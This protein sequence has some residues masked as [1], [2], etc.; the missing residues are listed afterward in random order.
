[1]AIQDHNEVSGYNGLPLETEV[2]LSSGLRSASLVQPNDKISCGKD[3]APKVR[4][5]YTITKQRERWTDEEHNKFLEAL[6]LHGRAWRKI[7]EHVGTKSAVQIRSHAQKYFT[8]VLRETAGSSISSVESIEIPPPRPKRKPSHPYPRKLVEFPDKAISNAGQPMRSNSLKS[9]E[10]DQENQ[11]PK[12]VLSAFGLDTPGY[13]DS[14]KPNGSPSE[15]DGSAPNAHSSPDL[16]TLQKFEL[17]P[18]E[19]VSTKEDA[20]EE[21][22]G[23]TF[24]LFGT[25]LLVTD[26]TMK[27]SDITEAPAGFAP[28]GR[29]VEDKVEKEVDWCGS[30]ITSSISDG[31]NDENP[32]IEARSHMNPYRKGEKLSLFGYL[33]TPREPS[34]I[35]EILQRPIGFV[36]YKRFIAERENQPLPITVEEKE[37]QRLRLSLL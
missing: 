13:S 12:S 18:R 6:K 35:S 24:K 37:G 19:S 8:K 3:H 33:T 31:D 26:P 15:E 29:E 9:S 4:K 22:C 21:T 16:Q 5:P 20:A 17:F 32:D 28:W 1:M 2:F 23:R 30:T 34:A 7:E 25:T 11:S 14:Y 27:N 36:P 10:S